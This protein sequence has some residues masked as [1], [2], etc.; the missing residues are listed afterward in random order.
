MGEATKGLMTG[1]GSMTDASVGCGTVANV[2]RVGTRV[3]W[4]VG[5][6]EP[7]LVPQ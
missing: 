5:G 1:L 3:G 6:E 7:G 4:V 2:F